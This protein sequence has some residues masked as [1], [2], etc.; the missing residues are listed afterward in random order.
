MS[1]S[2]STSDN[3]EVFTSLHDRINFLGPDALS[4]AVLSRDFWERYSPPFGYKYYNSSQTHTEQVFTLFG[5]VQSFES[6]VE[7]LR[8]QA[9]LENPVRQPLCITDTTPI[10]DV[11]LIRT[12]DGSPERLRHQFNMQVGL[13]TQ[14]RENHIKD[15]F[16]DVREWT[17]EEWTCQ[18]TIDGAMDTIRLHLPPALQLPENVLGT[19]SLRIRRQ[20]FNHR[21]EAPVQP[22]GSYVGRT[23]P[24]FK[25]PNYDD[26]IWACS[27]AVP[28]Q[29]DIRDH[30]GN[31]IPP[32]YRPL[33]RNVLIMCDVTLTCQVLEGRRM[34]RKYYRL[35]AERIRVLK[36]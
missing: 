2:T 17:Q 33:R 15:E 36:A 20:A 22:T 26:A 19:N 12:P 31:L 29:E 30:L 34:S 7:H 6:G 28:I 1:T 5:E 4:S 32:P 14:I 27:R 11:L 9:F 21:S 24:V 8:S 35:N 10:R 16:R 25:V 3:I 23:F 18:S 13:L